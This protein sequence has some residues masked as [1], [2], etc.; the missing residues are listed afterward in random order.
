MV[1]QPTSTSDTLQDHLEK[2][3]ANTWIHYCTTQKQSITNSLLQDIAIFNEHDSTK[4]GEWLTDV[5][6]AADLTSES[7]AT[8]CQQQSQEDQHV[9]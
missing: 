9:C 6:T 5:K 4:L 7:P 8:A 2:W 3:Y 1:A